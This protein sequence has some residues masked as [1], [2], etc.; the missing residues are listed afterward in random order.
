MYITLHH[1]THTTHHHQE[2]DPPKWKINKVTRARQYTTNYTRNHWQR[3][4]TKI[5][6]K[7]GLNQQ[8]QSAIKT[9]KKIIKERQASSHTQGTNCEA[10]EFKSQTHYP[11][12][13]IFHKNP[14]NLFNKNL[15]LLVH[16]ATKTPTKNLKTHFTQPT[17]TPANPNPTIARKIQKE[18]EREP[19][20]SMAMLLPLPW[21]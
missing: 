15:N 4:T 19:T 13:K 11:S 18:R 6:K 12:P 9:Q 14:A 2:A 10:N 21:G 3:T 1:S 7:I 8:Y 17:K 5:L 16:L 20:I